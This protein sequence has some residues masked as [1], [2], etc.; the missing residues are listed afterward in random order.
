MKAST[1]ISFGLIAAAALLWAAVWLWLH[2]WIIF[3]APVGALALGVAW[4][5]VDNAIIYPAQRARR[6]NGPE[7]G[8]PEDAAPAPFDTSDIT[9]PR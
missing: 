3:A 1:Q 9:V 2:N 5:G 8:A 4:V 7:V 6:Q